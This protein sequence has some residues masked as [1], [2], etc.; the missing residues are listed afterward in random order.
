M[1]KHEDKLEQKSPATTEI[2]GALDDTDLE[3][4]TGGDAAVVLQHEPV[5]GQ[6]TVSKGIF[7]I[8][9]LFFL[10]SITRWQRPS[11]RARIG[12]DACADRRLCGR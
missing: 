9:E 2:S 4:V 10:I 1:S 11:M 7:E 8:K 3:K 6:K 12:A 5:T